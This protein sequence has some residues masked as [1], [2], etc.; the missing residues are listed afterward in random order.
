MK[1]KWMYPIVIGI[2]CLVISGCSNT[3]EASKAKSSTV[4]KQEV[5][6]PQGETEKLYLLHKN[7]DTKKKY[8]SDEVILFLEPFSVPSAQAFDVPGYSWMDE[9]AKKGYDTWA[10]DFRGFGH[11]TRPKEMS[12]PPTQNRPV[13]HLS[14]ATKDLETAVKW[15]KKNRNVDKIDIIGWSY[16]GVVAGN[17]AISNPQD[18]NK[19]VLYGYMHGFTLPM[20]TQPLENSARPGE[21][22]PQTPAYQMI[23]FD[24]GMHHWHMMMGEKQIVT[25]EAM[26]AVKQVF[27]DSDPLSKQNNGAIRRPM[28][29]LEDLYSIWKNKPLY[30]ASKITA[31]VLVIYGKDDLFADHEMMAKLTGAKQKKEVVIPDATHWVIYEKHRDTLITETLKFIEEKAK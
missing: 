16:G 17:Y 11:S 28:G 18:V 10:M 12:E 24:K 27:V 30:D 19:L 20:M 21:F 8:T 1:I 23:D 31:P 4:V 13:I 5:E 29:P 3:K 6:V 25:D 22:N 2:I 14:D 7:L 26:N 9:Y 15:I